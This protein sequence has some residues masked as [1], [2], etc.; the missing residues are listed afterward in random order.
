MLTCRREVQDGDDII[1]LDIHLNWQFMYYPKPGIRLIQPWRFFSFVHA[2]T[3]KQK[4]KK[5]RGGGVCNNAFDNADV[6]DGAH[7]FLPDQEFRERISVGVYQSEHQIVRHQ[8]KLMY[9]F[10]LSAGIRSLIILW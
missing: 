8:F 1:I 7:V 6:K 10:K 5:G 2:W 9:T 3:E 4:K